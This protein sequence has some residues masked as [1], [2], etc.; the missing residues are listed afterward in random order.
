MWSQTRGEVYGSTQFRIGLETHRISLFID[1]W[2]EVWLLQR[3]ICVRQFFSPFQ[4]TVLE[5]KEHNS[6][7]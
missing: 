6:L 4:N 7:S 3:M 1:G 5:E 2:E